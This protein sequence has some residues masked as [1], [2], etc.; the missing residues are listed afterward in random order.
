MDTARG[1]VESQFSGLGGTGGIRWKGNASIAF[2]T[3]EGLYGDP[4]NSYYCTAKI[5]ANTYSDQLPMGR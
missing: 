4:R 2:D 5:F 1:Q 3:A